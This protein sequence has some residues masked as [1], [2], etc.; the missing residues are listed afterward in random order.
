MEKEKEICMKIGV[1]KWYGTYNSKTGKN[2]E[3]GFLTPS[4]GGDDLFFHKNGILP[5]YREDAEQLFK[6]SSVVVYNVRQNRRSG[7]NEAFQVKL[8]SSLDQTER[9]RLYRQ[10][11][12]QEDRAAIIRLSYVFPELFAQEELNF[13]LPYLDDRDMRSLFLDRCKTMELAALMDALSDEIYDPVIHGL[14][15]DYENLSWILPKIDWEDI[16]DENLVRVR[17]LLSRLKADEGPSAAVS[18]AEAM[19]NHAPRLP[20][21]WELFGDSL[22]IRILIYFSNF[23]AEREAWHGTFQEI[24][25]RGEEDLLVTAVLKFFMNIYCTDA[26]ER[27]KNFGTAHDALMDYIIRCF[28][29]GTDVTHGLRT[30]LEPCQDIHDKNN[31]SIGSKRFFCDARI[32]ANKKKIFCP[33]KRLPCGHY[34]TTDLTQTV[35]RKNL[36]RGQEYFDRQTMMDLLL[37]TGGIP[38]LSELGIWEN[39]E[40]P[41]RISAFV[42][43]LIQMRPHMKCS[44]CGEL[45][46]PKFQYAKQITVRLAMTVFACSKSQE[47]AGHDDSV[48]LN[49]CNSCHEIIDS[50]E[51]KFREHGLGPDGR[52]RYASREEGRGMFLCMHCGSAG[53]T[54]PG[55]VC[56][57]C[58][59]RGTVSMRGSSR[60]ICARCR[61]DSVDFISK[62]KI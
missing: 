46:H 4:E 12:D 19:R 40:Y 39:T 48:Y 42:N 32:W 52:V 3:Y 53:H 29:E 36:E 5:Q 25:E 49:F 58:S 9:E 38:D 45:F 62:F 43:S 54:E 6:E 33:R 20:A 10:S 37:N 59:S 30:L 2:N 15:T 21:W 28:N 18:I 1:M 22:K 7:K 60:I 55:T 8:L 34:E 51:C 44:C 41:F 35:F 31:S 26:A 61:Y 57:N 16:S 13:F 11:K 56:P 47:E 24:L 14:L 17:F 50:R 27:Q 23:A